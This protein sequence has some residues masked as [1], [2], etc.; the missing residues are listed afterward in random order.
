MGPG[1]RRRGARTPER[2]PATPSYTRAMPTPRSFDVQAIRGRFPSLARQV[3]G[4]PIV[5][6]DGP[7]GTQVPDLC[8]DGIRD[9][10][11]SHN[12]NTHGAF[13]TSVESDALLEEAHAAAADFLGAAA[14][15]VAFGANRITGP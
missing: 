11:T 1:G 14:D 5:Y 6:V 13:P 8:L 15:E 10:L 7:G 3:A 12:T 2:T 4:H 9:Y